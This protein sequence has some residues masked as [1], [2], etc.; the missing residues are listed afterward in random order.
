MEDSQKLEDEV[1][2]E[3]VKDE[4]GESGGHGKQLGSLIHSRTLHCVM[5]NY[6]T[7]ITLVQR[8]QG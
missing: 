8:M 7:S 4:M 5:L 1:T 6:L 2:S 3:E